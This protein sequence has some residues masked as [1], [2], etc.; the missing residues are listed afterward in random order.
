MKY[1]QAMKSKDKQSWTNAVKEESKIEQISTRCL[2]QY[3]AQ[4]SQDFDV[5]MGLEEEG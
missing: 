5:N 4:E 3:I 1:D 2:M